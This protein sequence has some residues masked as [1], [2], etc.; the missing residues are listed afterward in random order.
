MR[1]NWYLIQYQNIYDLITDFVEAN[2]LMVL[3]KYFIIYFYSIFQLIDYQ[4]IF[5]IHPG[6][7]LVIE[8]KKKPYPK[9]NQVA[10]MRKDCQFCAQD[11]WASLINLKTRFTLC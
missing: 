1:W 11:N 2:H 6:V 4:F 5:V 3:A 9:V 8:G 10:V 7:S